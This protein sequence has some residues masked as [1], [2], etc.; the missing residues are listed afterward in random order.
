MTHDLDY[1]HVIAALNNK[2]SSVRRSVALTGQCY[3]F[4]SLL[5]WARKGCS[6][7]Y[8]QVLFLPGWHYAAIHPCY[9]FT[10]IILNVNRFLKKYVDTK[11]FIPFY[12]QKCNDGKL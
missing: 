7:L 9:P 11:K 4:K 5:S 2:I 10:G 12:V 8:W 6:V 1:F 3:E